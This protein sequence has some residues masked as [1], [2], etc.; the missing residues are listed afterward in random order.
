MKKIRICVCSLILFLAQYVVYAHGYDIDVREIM[1]KAAKHLKRNMPE[2]TYAAW[3]IAK[4]Y[5]PA[6]QQFSW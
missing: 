2:I 4:S 1:R 5:H 6:M 3:T